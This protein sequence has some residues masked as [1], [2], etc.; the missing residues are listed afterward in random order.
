LTVDG[1]IVSF[2]PPGSFAIKVMRQQ[3]AVLTLCPC[4]TLPPTP[5]PLIDFTLRGGGRA[6][7][8]GHFVEK[9]KLKRAVPE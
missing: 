9:I 3:L 1:L 5:S 8:Y 4:H 6:G 7:I 2:I